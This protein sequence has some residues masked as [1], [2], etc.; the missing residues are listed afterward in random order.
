MRSNDAVGTVC[1]LFAIGVV[2]WLSFNSWARSDCDDFLAAATQ[3]VDAAVS[4]TATEQ[5]L[6]NCV[7]RFGAKYSLDTVPR[8]P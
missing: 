5:R 8:Q 7:E 2:A 3:G 1:A 6:D 4:N